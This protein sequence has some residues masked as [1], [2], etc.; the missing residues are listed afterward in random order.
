MKFLIPDKIYTL[1]GL[2]IKE[3]ILPKRF[4]PG[5]LLSN[6]TGVVKYVTV[7]NT[8]DINEAK[9][10]NDAEQYARATFNGNMKDVSVHYYIDET[11]CWHLLYDREMGLHATDGLNG[12]GNG[13]S[14]AIEIIMDG[15][16]SAAD[17]KAEARGAL[18]CAIKL[19]EYGLGISRLKTHKDW[20]SKKDCPLYILPHWDN[21]V[22]RVEYYLEE[23]R[24]LKGD[25]DGDGKITAADARIAL[26]A[27]VGIDK[28]TERQKK[29]AD[30]NGDGKITS[31]DAREILRESVNEIKVPYTL[32]IT[33]DEVEIKSGPG[34]NYPTVG[35]ITD[36]GVYTILEDKKGWGRLKSGIGWVKIV[37]TQSIDL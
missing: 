13:T 29:A 37:D 35:K 34:D 32:K 9:G 30:I 4:K 2:E 28:L 10:T 25:I 8:S 16:G 11:D 33:A 23:I 24:L 17:K 36:K 31:S 14:I 22:K 26:R 21:F 27:S 7:H 5:M 3:K 6:G 15:S 20:Y 19:H 1:Y 12:K 18:L